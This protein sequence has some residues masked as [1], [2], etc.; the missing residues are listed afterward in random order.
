MNWIPSLI[1]TA[2][3]LLIGCPCCAQQVTTPDSE[4]GPAPVVTNASDWHGYQKHSFTLAGHP[5]F[6][7]SPKIAASGKPWVWRTSFPDFHSEVDQ[8]LVY[9]G[10]HIGFIDVVKMLGSDSALDIMD[11]FY[12]QARSQWGLS[13]RPALEPCSRGGLHAY[14]YAARHPHRVA[15]ILGDVPVMDLKSWPMGWAGSKQQIEEAIHFYGFD[16]VAELKTFRGNPV[17]VLA[18][19]ANARIPIRHAICLNDKVVPPEQNTL[20]A[21]RRLRKLGHDMDLVIVQQSDRAD[22]HHFNMPKIFESARFVMQHTNVMPGNIEY[23]DLRNGLANSLTTFRSTKRGRIAFL[24]G[25]ITYGEGWRNELMR[26]FEKRFPETQF[27]FIAAGIPSVGSNGHAFRL[28]R[29]ILKNGPVDLLFVEAAVNDGSNIPES[30]EIMRRA[31]EGV[32]RH[33]RTV[34]PMTDIVHM[35]F[36]MGSHLDDYHAGRVPVPIAEHE[37]A[38]AHYGCTTLNITQEVADRIQAGEFTWQSGFRSNV[39]PPAFG[40]RVY[41]NSMTRMLDA[42]FKTTQKPKPHP[43][44]D[45]LV[46]PRSYISGRFG[47]LENAVLGKG[48]SLEQNWQPARG[49]TRA[50]FANVPALVA[51]EPG[52]EFCYE[53]QGTAFGLFL[54]AGYD[55]CILQFSIDG[56]DFKKVD[57]IT[58]WSKGLHL[59]WPLILADGLKP[60]KHTIT[61]QTT[62]DAKDRSALHVIH[63][64][65]N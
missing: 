60:G 24:G 7:V 14:R 57:S 53:F 17:D 13:K 2:L 50:G 37:K 56:S 42:A 44:P 15:C 36:A 49:G 27:D 39:H 58:R 23:F 18:P 29:D 31:M 41:S 28:Q 12:D 33:I 63:I 45:N 3:A 4:A 35:H 47:K 62:G 22:G 26:Y 20:E 34:N 11:Q 51:S 64:L 5:A 6:I 10:Y 32:V 40:H 43:V 1:T 59:P 48:F 38:A 30:P 52:A 61:V 46:D 19:I 55:S 9:N 25:S 16:S 65:E 21:Q 8:E 54:A